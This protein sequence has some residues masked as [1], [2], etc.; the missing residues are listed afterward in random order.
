M[1]IHLN[2][3]YLALGEIVI[4]IVPNLTK[5]CW[6]FHMQMTVNIENLREPK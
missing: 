4:L 3:Y 5:T 6:Q 1:G 2:R